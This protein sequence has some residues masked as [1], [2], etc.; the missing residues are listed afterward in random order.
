MAVT[1]PSVRSMRV[2]T[3]GNA[4]K[5]IGDAFVRIPIHFDEP[6]RVTLSTF[7]ESA[8][9]DMSDQIGLAVFSQAS[10][11]INKD[12]ITSWVEICVTACEDYCDLRPLW[13]CAALEFCLLY[14]RRMNNLKSCIVAMEPIVHN[15]QASLLLLRRVNGTD[16]Q[17]EVHVEFIA[18]DTE[19][20][21]SHHDTP[22]VWWD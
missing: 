18:C 17:D 12:G 1:N 9:V 13:P 2:P 6:T 20:L 16:G 19:T 4:R 5:R 3:G 22:I 14:A 7:F 8:S 10:L 21:R 11:G 15:G